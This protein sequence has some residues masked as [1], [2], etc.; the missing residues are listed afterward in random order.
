MNINEA[1]QKLEILQKKIYAYDAA[2]SALFLDGVTVAPPET[3]EGRG[4][5]LGILAGGSFGYFP[6][7]ALGSAY[8]AQ[9]LQNMEKEIDVWGAVSSGD[10]SMI[11]EWLR[12]NVH[13][14]GSYLKPAEIIRKSCGTFDPT[15]Y[16]DYLINKYADIYGI[17]NI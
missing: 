11:S 1:I 2:Q 3:S 16:V 8:G 15:I 14:Y 10:L 13:Q 9:M 17:E 5:A 6:S 4:M 12:E 7:Y